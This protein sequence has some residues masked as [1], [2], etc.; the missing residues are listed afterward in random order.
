MPSNSSM[1]SSKHRSLDILDRVKLPKPTLH[2]NAQ[3]KFE[4]TDFEGMFPVSQNH[5]LNVM[6]YQSVSK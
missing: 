4:S 5:D 1:E 3:G 6:I 2:R